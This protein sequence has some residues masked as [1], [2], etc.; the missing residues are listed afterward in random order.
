VP[1]DITR[2]SCSIVVPLICG[3][4]LRGFDRPGV[5]SMCWLYSRIMK[6]LVAPSNYGVSHRL[7]NDPLIQTLVC[8]V[9]TVFHVFRM[10][11]MY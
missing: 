6:L 5:S 10:Y 4:S 8:I 9:A 1:V 2:S 7:F 3:T 11:Q